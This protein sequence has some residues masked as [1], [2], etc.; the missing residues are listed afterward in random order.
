[1]DACLQAI[2]RTPEMYTVMYQGYRRALVR[3]FPYGIFYEHVECTVT[4]YAVFHSARAPGEWRH[5]LP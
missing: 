2:R 1:M 3:R 4:I 5:R